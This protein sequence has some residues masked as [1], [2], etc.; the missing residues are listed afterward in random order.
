M[1]RICPGS[2][3]EKRAAYVNEAPK[4]IDF[5]VDQGIALERGSKFWPDY[6]DELPGGCKT[7]RTVAA[8]PFNTKELGPWEGKL[9]Q[10]LHGNAGE[11][12]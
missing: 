12:R 10:G 3:H 5:L 7:S 11:A 2:S 8:K 9:R 6:Y 1:P 4:M